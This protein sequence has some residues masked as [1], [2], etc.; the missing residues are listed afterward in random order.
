MRRF[1]ALRARRLAVVD[2]GTRGND[3]VVRPA[4]VAAAV[5][6][7][8]LVTIACGANQQRIGTTAYISA[9]PQGLGYVQQRTLVS[10]VGTTAAVSA[11]VVDGWMVDA[12][13]DVDLAAS[14]T[15][16]GQS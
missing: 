3:A 13:I 15:A 5:L 6:H 8:T 9:A 10:T 11:I 16:T 1:T 4:I 7:R 2:H 12:F 14:A